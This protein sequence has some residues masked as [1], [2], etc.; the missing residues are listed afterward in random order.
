M[1]RL[2]S[3]IAIL[4]AS[5]GVARAQIVL[6]GDIQFSHLGG[7]EV[8]DGSETDQDE[9]NAFSV[10]PSVGY[11][12]SPKLLI[13]LQIGA[14]ITSL[15]ENEGFTNVVTTNNAFSIGPFVRFDAL[16]MNKFSIYIQGGMDYSFTKKKSGDN[17]DI[18]TNQIAF[19]IYPGIAYKL[20]EKIQLWTNINLLNLNFTHQSQK[21]TINGSETKDVTNM[22]YF[23]VDTGNVLNLGGLN[24]GVYFI[25]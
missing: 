18:K 7:K 24:V 19:N 9:I 11:M 1:K 17:P 4:I 2:F 3:I 6:G 12:L 14:Q 15:K 22:F 23:G 20:S 8:A 16:Q 25:L 10:M 13:G 5:M 21:V